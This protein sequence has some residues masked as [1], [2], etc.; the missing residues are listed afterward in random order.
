MSFCSVPSVFRIDYLHN[1]LISLQ[2]RIEELDAQLN[3]VKR[4]AK[5]HKDREEALGTELEETK[6][7]LGLFLLYS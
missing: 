3:K 5:K 7:D 4:E 1:D 2:E 6:N